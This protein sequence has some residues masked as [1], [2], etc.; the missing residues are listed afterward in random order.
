LT[1]TF[2][3]RCQTLIL[4]IITP[5]TNTDLANF[6]RGSEGGASEIPG[7]TPESHVDSNIPRKEPFPPP[8][9]P[10]Q[11]VT[12]L[13][14]ITPT[15][16]TDLAVFGRGSEGGAGEIPGDTPESHVDRGQRVA[17]R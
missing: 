16:S 2:K 7:D 8:P 3:C 10:F 9:P 11:K 4:H 15:T 1:A 6:G 17:L 14:I 13:H 5:T 12:T